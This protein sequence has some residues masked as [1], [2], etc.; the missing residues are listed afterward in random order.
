[1]HTVGNRLLVVRCD[2]AHLPKLYADVIDKRMKPVGRVMDVF[3]NVSAPCA[4]ILCRTPA[5]ALAGEMLFIK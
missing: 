3:G 2:P 1:M 5:R 4:A